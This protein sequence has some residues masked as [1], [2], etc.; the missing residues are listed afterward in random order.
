MREM[1]TSIIMDA[2]RLS[3]PLSRAELAGRTGL[4]RST[5][6]LIIDDLIERGFVQETTTSQDAKVGRPGMLL[7]FDPE[8][9]CVV[10][11][12]IGVD[13]ISVILTNF[14]GQVLWRRNQISTE[15][16]TQIDRLQNAEDFISEALN[17]GKQLSLRPLGIGVGVPGLVD[18]RQG[19]L[20][21]APNLHWV[22]VPLRLLWM[23]RF[24]LPVFVE[25]EAN[26]ACMGEY[27]YGTAHNVKDFLFLKTGVGLGGGIMI[28]GK[29]FR[30]ASGYAGEI[31]HITI[32][33]SD[34]VCACGRKGCWETFVRPSSLLVKISER[35]KN[36]EASLLHEIVGHDLSLLSVEHIAEAARRNDALTLSAVEALAVHFGIGIANLVNVFNPELVVLGGTLVPLH[37]W[38]IPVIVNTMKANALPPL[39]EITRVEPSA[40]GEDACLLGAV[41]LVM[42]DILREPLNIS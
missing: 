29:I 26:C 11:V 39:R 6:S 5:V 9:G 8:G 18:P 42:D 20:I 7:Q 37:H 19:K 21:F 35:L 22:D 36:G 34:T 2:I 14:I 16:E 23:H 25:N 4:T 10:G 40:H 3:A 27:F 13:F 41:A 17:Y 32:Y 15:Q 28:D 31:G 1:N 38:M 33:E 24:D 30:G 12:E